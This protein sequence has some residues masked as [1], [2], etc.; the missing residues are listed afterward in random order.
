MLELLSL[1]VTWVSDP[2]LA[3]VQVWTCPNGSLESLIV[4]IYD[5]TSPTEFDIPKDRYCVRMLVSNEHGE[6]DWSE[7][8]VTLSIPN[9]PSNLEVL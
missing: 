7:I 3:R 4:E 1:I 5:D 6:S 8:V 9:P 2:G